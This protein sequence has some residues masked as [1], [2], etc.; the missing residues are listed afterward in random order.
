M[1]IRVQDQRG[2]DGER[3]PRLALGLDQHAR[4]GAIGVAGERRAGEPASGRARSCRRSNSGSALGGED[5]ADAAAWA[6]DPRRRSS[7]LGQRQRDLVVRQRALAVGRRV[8][9]PLG[10]KGGLVATRSKRPRRQ[11][12]RARADVAFHQLEPL[13][14]AVA[15]APERRQ[16]RQPRLQLDAD[17]RRRRIARRAAR[18]RARRCRSRCRG[19]ARTAAR[20]SAASSTGSRLAR[21]PRAR[22][23]Q[24]DPPAEQRVD[25]GVVDGQLVFGARRLVRETTAVSAGIVSRVRRSASDRSDT[26]PGRSPSLGWK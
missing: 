24:R 3:A 7:P 13:D 16:P 9:L 4:R 26:S 15:R 11:R 17:A 18:R 23:Q 21:S 5:H 14:D 6:H 10:R 22:L 12:G 2:L 1:R 19:S 25:G 20:G 8:P